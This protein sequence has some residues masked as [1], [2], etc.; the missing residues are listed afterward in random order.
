MNTTLL[1]FRLHHTSNIYY[2][3]VDENKDD[4]FLAALS[5]S[6]RRVVCPS[7]GPYS[8]GLSV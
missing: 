4:T 5:S 7:V 8:V 1:H 3:D 2:V 6:R